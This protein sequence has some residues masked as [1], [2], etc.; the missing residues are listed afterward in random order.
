MLQRLTFS[1]NLRHV[2]KNQTPVIFE[3]NIIITIS[4]SVKLGILSIGNL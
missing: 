2:S 3:H 1:Q 4:A